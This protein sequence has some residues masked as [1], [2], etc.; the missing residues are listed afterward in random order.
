MA[1][2]LTSLFL[3]NFLWISQK[4]V[5][6]L[7]SPNFL[8]CKISTLYLRSLF[9]WVMDPK[10]PFIQSWRLC[11]YLECVFFRLVM[12]NL[13]KVRNFNTSRGSLERRDM[14]INS[15]SITWDPDGSLKLLAKPTIVSWKSR[16]LKLLYS[17][18]KWIPQP[19]NLPVKESPKMVYSTTQSPST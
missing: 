4:H 8:I 3:S 7:W 15:F 10:V 17:H 14:A 5:L 19:L 13:M 2:N 9:P 6:L 1:A 11:Y 16:N 18:R 12:K